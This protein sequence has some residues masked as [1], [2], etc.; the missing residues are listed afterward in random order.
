MVNLVEGFR[1]IYYH[2]VSLFAGFHVLGQLLHELQQ[3]GFTGSIMSK[4]VLSGRKD[5]VLLKMVHE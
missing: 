1:E 4:A 2:D 5:V 3:L